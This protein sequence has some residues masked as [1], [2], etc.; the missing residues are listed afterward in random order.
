MFVRSQVIKFE[1][2]LSDRVSESEK[3]F[4]IHLRLWSFFESVILC[5]S[6]R[7]FKR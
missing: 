4:S 5:G 2:F 3:I 7:F 6:I 1:K